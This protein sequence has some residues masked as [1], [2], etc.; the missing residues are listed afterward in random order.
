MEVLRITRPNLWSKVSHK[1]RGLN[2]RRHFHF[3]KTLIYQDILALAA[4]FEW[5][6]HQMDVKISFTNG[7]VEEENYIDQP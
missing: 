4:Q 7:V 2:M 1:W 6:I 5:R 3:G